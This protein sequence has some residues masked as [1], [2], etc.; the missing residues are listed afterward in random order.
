MK[1]KSAWI[2][3]GSLALAAP[4]LAPAAAADEVRGGDPLAEHIGSAEDSEL[5]SQVR[6]K[7]QGE[8]ALAG[9]GVQ[10][11]DGAVTLTGRVP[12]DADRRR[13]EDLAS[14]VDGVERVDNRIQVAA[15]SPPES[16]TPRFE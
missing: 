13:A 6:E 2:L 1:R 7:L 12:S 16:Q 4:G 3:A 14:D 9:V 15:G 10:V 8:D 11:R 5:V